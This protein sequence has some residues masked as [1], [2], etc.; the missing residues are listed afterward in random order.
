VR[1]IYILV[2]NI[3]LNVGVEILMEVK[4]FLQVAPWL[5]LAIPANIVVDLMPIAFFEQAC[6]VPLDLVGWD[7]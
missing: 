5:V 7:L 2:F 3:V 4:E 1:V 6:R